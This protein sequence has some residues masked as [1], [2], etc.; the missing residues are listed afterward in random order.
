M[1]SLKTVLCSLLLIGSTPLTTL[2]SQRSD[3]IKELN[4]LLNVSPVLV[5]VKA[6]LENQYNVRCGIY[7]VDENFTEIFRARL[8]CSSKQSSGYNP[9]K[10][11]VTVDGFIIE[12]SP[13][14]FSNIKIEYQL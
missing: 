4:R 2:A 11:F 6:G 12:E 10:V 14:V 7:G 9:R 13:L 3:E 8:V 5:S 1:K